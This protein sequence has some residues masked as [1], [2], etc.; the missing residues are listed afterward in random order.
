MKRE[1]YDSEAITTVDCSYFDE[2]RAHHV[3]VHPTDPKLVCM[4]CHPPS[5]KEA[6]NGTRGEAI[7]GIPGVRGD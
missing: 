3:L 1:P 4:I 5:G 7:D 6:P 2:H